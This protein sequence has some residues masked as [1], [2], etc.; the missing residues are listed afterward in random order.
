MARFVSKTLGPSQPII[1]STLGPGGFTMA[2]TRHRGGMTRIALS[3]D[4]DLLAREPLRKSLLA[5]SATSTRQ[6]VVDLT[7]TRFLDCSGIG[8][9]VAGRNAAVAAGCRFRVVHAHGIVA[10]VLDITGLTALLDGEDRTR[11]SAGRCR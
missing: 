3:G 4:V 10:R 8:A 1:L 5:A 9:L 6:L 11:R 2:E 7:V